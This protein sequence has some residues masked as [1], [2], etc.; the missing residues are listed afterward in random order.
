MS[1]LWKWNPNR[2][3]LWGSALFA[4][5]RS[6]WDHLGEN[7]QF[8]G[9]ALWGL[10]WVP[11]IHSHRQR[12]HLS[13]WLWRLKTHLASWRRDHALR[14]RGR[15]MGPSLP[16]ALWHFHIALR[17][18]FSTSKTPNLTDFLLC[19]SHYL[20]LKYYG[21]HQLAIKCWL[22]C[23]FTLKMSFDFRNSPILGAWDLVASSGETADCRRK[24]CESSYHEEA[25][26]LHLCRICPNSGKTSNILNN[27]TAN[28]GQLENKQL[29]L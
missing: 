6:L 14:A 10:I 11:H 25:T 2:T 21:S 24:L 9:S 20:S 17:P 18:Y 22:K 7:L 13:I 15:E 19:K 4:V 29:D 26:F 3:F 5:R 27:N 1:A 28:N 16:G 23:V 12:C 8:C